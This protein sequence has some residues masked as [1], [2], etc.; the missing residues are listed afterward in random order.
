MCEVEK[1]A[2]SLSI[3][4]VALSDALNKV[5]SGCNDESLASLK[6]MTR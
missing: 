3:L 2:H 6:D 5:E 1:K 4:R